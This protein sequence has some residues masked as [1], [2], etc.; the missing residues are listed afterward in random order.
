[1]NSAGMVAEIRQAGCHRGLTSE[2]FRS[3]RNAGLKNSLAYSSEDMV[4]TPILIRAKQHGDNL[5][6]VI[7]TSS[8]G[9]V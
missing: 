7:I 4:N 2:P 8:L 3:V 6:F 9:F 5:N 1:M